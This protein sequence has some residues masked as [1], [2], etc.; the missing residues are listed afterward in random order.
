MLFRSDK[1]MVYG[2]SLMTGGVIGN[3]IDRIRLGFVVD[4]F[5]IAN[6][7]VFNIADSAI[8][9]GIVLIGIFILKHDG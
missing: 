2:L 8:V 9:V 7:P 3:L 6:F 5:H 1:I 4:Y